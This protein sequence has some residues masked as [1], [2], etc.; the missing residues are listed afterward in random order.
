MSH[1]RREAARCGRYN[2]R[3]PQHTLKGAIGITIVEN[4]QIINN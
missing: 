2:E 1:F 4:T 3:V